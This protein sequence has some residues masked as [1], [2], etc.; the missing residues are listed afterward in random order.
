MYLHPDYTSYEELLAT[1]DRMLIK[2]PNLRYVGCHLS[3]MEWSVDVMSKWL[4]KFPI[5]GLDMAVRIAHF[6]V[7]DR[8]K[9]WGFII[10]YQNN[11]LYGTD[12]S[13]SDKSSVSSIDKAKDI[14]A[15]IWL[16]DWEYFNY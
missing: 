15:N 10:K 4:D 7:Q 8:D 3:S 6:K 14:N 13:F 16:I 9:V 2:H 12:I 11:L 1:R 5:Y